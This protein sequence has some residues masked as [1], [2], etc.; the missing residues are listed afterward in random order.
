MLC[1]GTLSGMAAGVDPETMFIKLSRDNDDSYPAKLLFMDFRR[2]ELIK[3][4]IAKFK[5]AD[6]HSKSS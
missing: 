1:I 4:F 3:K 6:L 2:K 5:G